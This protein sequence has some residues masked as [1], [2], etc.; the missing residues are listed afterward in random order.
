MKTQLQTILNF[1][2]FYSLTASTKIPIK[3]AYKLSRLADEIEKEINFYRT[4]FRETLSE[5]CLVDEDGNYA[6]TDDGTGYKIQP[7]KE[8]ECNQAMEDLHALEIELPD[9]TFTID[10]FDGMELRIQ[11]LNGIMPFIVD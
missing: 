7:G 8:V 3:T 10:E 2:Q 4:K 9:I 5:Y 1:P 6:V 11:D